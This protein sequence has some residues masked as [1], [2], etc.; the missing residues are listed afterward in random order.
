MQTTMTPKENKQGKD[1]KNEK[2]KPTKT[3]LNYNLTSGHI[4]AVAT[5]VHI[6]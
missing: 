4:T 2:K 3:P 6:H 1:D 5:V